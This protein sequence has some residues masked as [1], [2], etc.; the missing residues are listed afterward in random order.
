MFNFLYLKKKKK[1]RTDY[2]PILTINKSVNYLSK[3][4][5]NDQ[6]MKRSV[7]NIQ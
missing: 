5:K 2:H 6:E 1:K 4:W 7:N 3:Q